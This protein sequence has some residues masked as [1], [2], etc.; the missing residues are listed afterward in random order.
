MQKAAEQM[1]LT[2]H[3][4]DIKTPHDIPTAF[5]AAI[6]EGVKGAVVTEESMFNVHRA[7]LAKEAADHKIPVV[8]P[9]LLPVTDDLPI[10]ESILLRATEIID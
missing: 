3:V 5:A 10:P 7:S 8:Y 1:R 6:S 2:L 4:H 9:F